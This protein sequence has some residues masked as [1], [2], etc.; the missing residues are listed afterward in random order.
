[1]TQVERVFHWFLFGFSAAGVLF[2]L[3][4]SIKYGIKDYGHLSGMITLITS[5][6]CLVCACAITLRF[7]CGSV[8]GSK[9]LL[10]MAISLRMSNLVG[11]VWNFKPVDDGTSVRVGILVFSAAWVLS[12]TSNKVVGRI[13]LVCVPGIFWSSQTFAYCIGTMILLIALGIS[14]ENVLF[15]VFTAVGLTSAWVVDPSYAQ[16]PFHASIW[17]AAIAST[18]RRTL[19]A[20]EVN[21]DVN[22]LVAVQKLALLFEKKRVKEETDTGLSDDE[23]GVIAKW[24]MARVRTLETNKAA[25]GTL[26]FRKVAALHAQYKEEGM[27]GD[28][29]LAR[30]IDFVSGDTPFCP[31]DPDGP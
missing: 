9:A 29:A 26:P 7:G 25:I 30:A 13:A 23:M 20:Q 22:L 14:R 12:C 31:P 1:M 16:Y 28:A 21:L 24:A 11:T 2:G 3:A 5:V 10:F 6:V 19:E 8:S 4:C 17:L 27:T 18:R 15:A